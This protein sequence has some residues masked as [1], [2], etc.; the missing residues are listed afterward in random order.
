MTTGLDEVRGMIREFYGKRIQRTEDLAASS[1]CAPETASRFYETLKL[2][3]EEVKQRQYGCGSPIPPDDLTGLT[4]V[5]LGSGAGTDAFVAASLVGPGGRV[6]GLDMT[7]EQLLVARRNVAPVMKK[8]GFERANVSFEKDF[9]E[10]A[11]TVESGSAD[12]VISNCVIN[13]SPRKDLVFRAIHR[14]LKEGGEFYISDIVCDRRLPDEVRRDERA[15]GE[16]L[17]GAEYVNDLRD[18]M[19]AAGFRDVRTVSRRELDA[20]VGREAARF[21]SMT[22]RGFKL[23]LD[24]RCEDFGQ[25]ATYR[26]SCREQPV[27]FR[28]DDGHGFEAG[29]PTPVCRNTA[30]ML[31]KTRFARHFD[32]TP[33]VKHFGAFDCKPVAPAAGCCG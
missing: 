19:E 17:A 16:C 7:D 32:V 28:L 1:C 15:Y 2:I 9:I 33:E 23:D 11:D 22:L 3:P 8:L 27:E 24:R 30:R 14:I 29:R 18:V 12:L 20:A 5:D 31:T 21:C 26:G 10:T 25:I 6:I 13:L 4:V